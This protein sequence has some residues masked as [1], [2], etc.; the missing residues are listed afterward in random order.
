[1]TQTFRP[2]VTQRVYDVCIV[3]SQ[4]GGVVAGALL[5]RRGF[6]VLHV[7]HDDPGFHYVD[8]GYVLPFGP[9]VIPSPR[10]LP[11]AEAVLSELGL[12]TDVSR[13]LVATHTDLQLL[14]PRHRVDLAREPEALRAELRREW[15]G[16]AEA[17]E[18]G[19]VRLGTLFDHAA[20]FLR[21]SPPLPPQGFGERWAVRK[22]LKLASSM[23]GAPAEP[24]GK[25]RPFAGLEDHELA[26]SL[27]V[28]HRF[29]GYRDGP[30]SPLSLVRLLGG[31]FRGTQRLPGGLGTLR[32]LVRRRIAESRGELRGGPGEPALATGLELA[33]GRIEAVRLAGSPDA[34]VARAFVAAI[35][36]ERLLAL[37]PADVRAGR[38]A[39]PLRRVRVSRQLLVL[40]LVV[41]ERA[42][43]PALGENVLALRDAAGGDGLDNAV[44]LQV[45]P[46]LKEG[47]KGGGE[48]V[49][50][51]ESAA[52]E[53]V[54][55]A[56]AFVPAGLGE[57]AL[58]ENAAR[59]REAVAEAI[60]FFERHLVAESAPLLA[61]PERAGMSQVHPLYLS[62]GEDPLGIAG[63]PVRSPWK[64]L[65]FAGRE[66]VPGLGIEGEFYAGIQ[67]AGHVA[68]M[69]GAKNALR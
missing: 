9:A 32:E 27:L 26:R 31:A 36:A 2:P 29:L 5:A 17:L 67:A 30:A 8:H 22:A 57:A 47:R 15:P 43:P 39:A 14:L 7:S 68:A 19:F 52:D 54:V 65:L 63:L 61:D 24:V 37:F 10:Q 51:G 46:A 33:H 4:L 6:R 20:F 58:R 12:T 35:D 25:A 44:F 23:P 55:C 41:K 60:P 18:Q 62:E 66:V 53:R 59:L 48:K 69:L 40:N 56:S 13:A 64:N 28:A 45:L 11:A 1:L 50:Q 38:Q 21:A 3:G 34:H 16:Q 42:L 49:A